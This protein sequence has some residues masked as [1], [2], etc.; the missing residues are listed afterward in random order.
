MQ[1]SN[2]TRHQKMHDE[3]HYKANVYGTFPLIS[4]GINLNEVIVSG[5]SQM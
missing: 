1:F 5:R 2:L 4:Y 3:K